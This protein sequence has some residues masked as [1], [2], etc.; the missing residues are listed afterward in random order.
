MAR[1][2]VVMVGKEDEQLRAL[3]QE[4]DQGEGNTL[5]SQSCSCA[6]TRN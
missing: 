6:L 5:E 4:R 3:A 1:A 2:S